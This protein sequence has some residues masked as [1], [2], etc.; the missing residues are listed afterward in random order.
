MLILKFSI[1]SSLV[2][3]S[4]NDFDNLK[5]KENVISIIDLV[6]DIYE[7]ELLKVID[8]RFNNSNTEKLIEFIIENVIS[9]EVFE[10]K[11]LHSHFVDNEGIMTKATMHNNIKKIEEMKIIK[12]VAHGKY[13]LIDK[14][15]NT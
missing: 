9:D 5:E 11:L 3:I 15:S 14:E 4:E 8:E 7:S 13:K 12:K 6:D 2:S 10:T 1:N